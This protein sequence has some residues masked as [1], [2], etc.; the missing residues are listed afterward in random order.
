M[1]CQ[2]CGADSSVSGTRKYKDVMLRRERKCFNGH[3]FTTYEV[4]AVNLDR[5]TMADTRRGVLARAKSWAL[6]QA[7]LAQPKAAAVGLA[8]E[9]NCTEAYVRFVRGGC[10]R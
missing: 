9:L 1:K 7:I 4:F 5:R 3:S 6:K 10:R 8:A 2:K